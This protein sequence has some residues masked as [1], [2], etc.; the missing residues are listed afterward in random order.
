VNLPLV[1]IQLGEGFHS[2]EA[3]SIVK[4]IPTLRSLSITD[5][6]KLTDADLAVIAGIGQLES[7]TIASLPLS[8]ERLPALVPFARL[9]A[10]TLALRPQSYPPETQAKVRALLPQVDVKFVK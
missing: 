2:A 6:S 9:K 8:D 10:L 5:G 7:L 1:S 4:A 3:F